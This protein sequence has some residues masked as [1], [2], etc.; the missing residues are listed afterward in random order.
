MMEFIGFI[1]CVLLLFVFGWFFKVLIGSI[2]WNIKDIFGPVVN[3]I[4]LSDLMGDYTNEMTV[5]ERTSKIDEIA[6]AK[7]TDVPDDANV[8]APQEYIDKYKNFK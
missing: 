7:V 4:D 3:D 2:I 8:L 5:M 1:G 6:E